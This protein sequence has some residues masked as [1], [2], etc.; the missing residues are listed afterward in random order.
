MLAARRGINRCLASLTWQAAEKRESTTKTPG[1]Q[2][3][4]RNRL[5]G[6][7]TDTSSCLCDFVVGYEFFSTLPGFTIH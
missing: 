6:F 7:L 1:H 3:S 5:P 4:E 2:D